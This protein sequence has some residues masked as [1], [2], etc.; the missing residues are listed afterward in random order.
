VSAVSSIR[1]PGHVAV[2]FVSYAA[3]LATVT[4][5]MAFV[6]NYFPVFGL[7]GVWFKALDAAGDAPFGEAALVDALLIA[8]FG[9]QHSVMARRSF[10]AWSAR[11]VPA[12]L[13]RSVYMLASTACLALLL[14]MWRPLGF[15]LL[16]VS[17]G[18]LGFALVGLAL[19]GWLVA[20]Y[21]TFLIDH[22]GL[23]GLSQVLSPVRRRPERSD[24]FRVPGLYRAVRHPLYFGFLLAFWATPIMSA[25]HLLFAGGFTVYV[26]IA[27]RFE[28]RDLV[29][30]FGD[31]YLAYRKRVRALLPFPR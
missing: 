19:V 15:V 1:H 31:P 28:E 10:K 5:A 16:D 29:E 26:L 6:G 13:E 30:R 2:S 3:F 8:A 11:F 7:H 23:F 24:D 20:A 27:I 21:S 17:N 9:V 25:A 22:A 4:Y 18:A 14:A 12:P